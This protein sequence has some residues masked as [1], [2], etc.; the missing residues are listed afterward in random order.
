MN[1]NSK[2]FRHPASAKVPALLSVLLTA[3]ALIAACAPSDTGAKGTASAAARTAGLGDLGPFR[4]T[5][6][7]VASLVSNGD[8][9]GGKSRI[10]DL[11]VAWDNAEAGLKPRAPADW[12]V[13]DKAIDRALNALRA[14]S[15]QA[16]DCGKA[17]T[18]L[19]QVIDSK[20]G[21]LA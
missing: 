15:P 9:A 2:P 11:E 4:A 18:D 10:K 8:L 13:V 17:M 12:H 19:L 14:S 21:P 6:A 5:A 7:D 1:I 20:S 3:T 16:A